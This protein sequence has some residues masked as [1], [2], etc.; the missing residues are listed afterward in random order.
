[1]RGLF[2]CLF[3]FA[4]NVTEQTISAAISES[5]VL[6]SIMWVIFSKNTSSSANPSNMQI[7]L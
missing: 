6:K 1:M 7:L 4:S 5:S 2:Y 3:F